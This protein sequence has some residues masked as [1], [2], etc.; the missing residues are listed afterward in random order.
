MESTHASCCRSRRS[1]RSR[2]SHQ[3]L[4]CPLRKKWRVDSPTCYLPFASH[5]IF[6]LPLT[7]SSENHCAPD[8]LCKNHCGCTKKADILSRTMHRLEVSA[9]CLPKSTLSKNSCFLSLTLYS[10]CV[11]ELFLFPSLNAHTSY[12]KFLFVWC[13]IEDRDVM[14]ALSENFFQPAPWTQRE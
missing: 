1:R 2:R 5:P 11:L 10:V 3:Q 6:L 8:C 7:F 4:F 13:H 9:L 12:S 14:N